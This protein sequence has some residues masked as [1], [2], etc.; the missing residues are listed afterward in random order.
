MA[1]FSSMILAR[2]NNNPEIL[3]S[4]NIAFGVG[5]SIGA[6]IFSIWGG[7]KLRIHGML[8]GTGVTEFAK[9]LL[10]LARDPLIWIVTATSGGFFMPWLGSCNQAIW[11]SK[12]EPGIQ[13]RIFASRFLIA[14][15]TTPL[16]LGISGPLD[17]NIFEP[18]MKTGGSLANIFGGLFGT[19]AGAGMALQNPLF[20]GL[21]IV[22]CLCGYRFHNLRNVEFILPDH[23]S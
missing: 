12:V 14:Q 3:A 6:M 5:A 17:D 15:I 1:V 16:G 2:T 11:L 10:S 9:I 20:S 4:V 13:G 22:I 21:G 18:A 23:N 19:G 7:L 8:I